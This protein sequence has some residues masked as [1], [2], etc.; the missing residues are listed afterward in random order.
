M[1]TDDD[2]TKFTSTIK[3]LLHNELAPIYTHLDH[4]EAGSAQTTN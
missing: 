3:I 1:L 2:M 4:L